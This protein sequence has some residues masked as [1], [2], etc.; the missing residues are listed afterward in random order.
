MKRNNWYQKILERM[1]F[2][3]TRISSASNH[4]SEKKYIDFRVP[5]DPDSNHAGYA[6]AMIILSQ[7]ASLT[8]V[9]V[10][11][12]VMIGWFFDI[13]ILKS[14]N[15]GFVSMKVNTAFCFILA[16][17]SL[18]LFHHT[19][20]SGKSRM[21]ARALALLLIIIGLLTTFEYILNIDAGIDQLLMHEMQGTPGTYSPGRMALNTAICFLLI[22]LSLLAIDVKTRRENIFSQLISMALAFVNL[23]SLFG[24][25]F[26]VSDLYKYANY[27]SMALHTAATFFILSIGIFCFRPNTGVILVFSM[28]NLG[29]YMVRRLLPVL[30]LIPLVFVWLRMAAQS[31]GFLS[32]ILGLQ[33]ISLVIISVF[34][35][36]IWRIAISINILESKS[37]ESAKEL[38]LMNERFSMAARAAKFGVWDW[39]IPKNLL[40][41][42]DRMYELYGVTKN[43]FAGGYE[44]WSNGLHPDDRLHS[45][46]ETRK[47]LAGEKEYNTEFRIIWPDGSVRYLKAFGN[48]VRDKSGNPLRMTGINYDI[49]EQ[50]KAERALRKSEERF[51]TTLDNMIEGCQLVGFDWR[52][53]YINNMAEI[54]NKRPKEEMLGQIMTDVW[55]GIDQTEVYAREQKCMT[56]RT[57]EYMENEFLFPDGSKGWFEL[58]MQPMSEGILILSVDI[59]ER[60]KTEEKL[61]RSEKKY[62]YLFD[63][64][65]LPLWIFDIETMAFLEVNESAIRHYGY[66]RKEFLNMTI[67]DI[68]LP[69]DIEA[70]YKA[71]HAPK[72]FN[73]PGTWR[74]IKKN[75]EHIFVEIKA[76]L[77]DYENRNA[78][79]V[80]ANDVTERMKADEEIKKLNEELEQRV[81]ER[82]RQ[83]QESNKEL[84][85]F[86]YS[87][88]HDL[89]APL[90]HV[91]GFSEKLEYTLKDKADSETNRLTGK[92]KTAASKMGQ[93]I[94]ELLTY[95]RLGRTDLKKSTMSLTAI[96]GEI[97][98]DASDLN[99]SRDI[100]WNIQELPEVVADPTLIRLVFQNLINNA[101]K[102]T[103]KKE[104]ARI[105]I[106]YSNPEENEYIFSVKDN[107]AGFNMQYDNKLFGVFQRLHT[108][109][110]FEGTGIGL[111]TVRRI[112]A[113]H[114]GRVWAE[115]EEEKGAVFY[116]TLPKNE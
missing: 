89:R 97:I 62:K 15:V 114:G 71:A 26:N 51:R 64:N 75:G 69:E 92:I 112:V 116:F 79:L 20:R 68:R 105:E 46:E 93:L 5:D 42:D 49:T 27:T 48:I 55:P 50:K 80:L 47:V 73:Q 90:R 11:I 100:E 84:E 104:K 37:S 66:S 1:S 94:D 19:T 18:Y 87:V 23:L 96:V 109:E 10:G 13:P 14:L 21:L 95:S 25:A 61:I 81:V 35:F 12:L 85:S 30:L 28:N 110:D 32:S 78:R 3:G 56:A 54:H 91:I 45:E 16:G 2:T 36:L 88:S 103:G 76:H 31:T 83:L 7:V 67:M 44:A 9:A 43:D 82:T 74:H 40:V 53:L 86:A 52:Y 8:A 77:I 106:S 57:I 60:K 107:G 108:T 33:L 111:A 41:W 63:M 59:T 34:I 102:F 99:D 6:R 22:G 17:L 70:A 115:G 39:D 38:S 98:N 24:Y 113:R 29:G 58:R 4:R 65:P 101:V 72:V